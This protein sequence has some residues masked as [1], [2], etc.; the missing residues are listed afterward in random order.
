MHDAPDRLAPVFEIEDLRTLEVLLDP[1]R[2]RILIMVIK[3]ALTVKEIADELDTP[4]TGLY[5]HVN[6]LADAGVIVVTATEKRGAA[7]RRRYRAVALEYRPA[8]SLLAQLHDDPRMSEWVT[9][10]VLG[11]ARV[12][13]EDM[14]EARR[15]DP[16]A[17]P[18]GALG[19]VFFVLDPG[20]A[21]YWMAKMADVIEEIEAEAEELED[22]ELYGFTFVLAPVSSPLVGTPK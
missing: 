10:L 8:E 15:A 14:L 7:T 11:G 4:V 16:E 12:D 20:R 13:A 18:P 3:T 22:G 2:I 21:A 17:G 9:G 6:M 1:L 19:R 5:Y